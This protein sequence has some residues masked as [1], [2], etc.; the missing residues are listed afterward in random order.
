MILALCFLEAK[1]RCSQMTLRLS[2]LEKKIDF[3]VREDITKVLMWFD[4]SKLFINAD[5]FEVFHFSR[6]QPETINNKDQRLYYRAN[7]KYNGF[8]I[9]PLV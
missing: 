6:G 2:M 4:L 3:F 9:D 8:H 1:K 7:C 5:N